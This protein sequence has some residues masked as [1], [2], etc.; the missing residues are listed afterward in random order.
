M[1][2]IKRHEHL[3]VHARGDGRLMSPAYFCLGGERRARPVLGAR[4]PCGAPFH[5][6]RWTVRVHGLLLISAHYPHILT[7]GHAVECAQWHTG[8][9]NVEKIQGAESP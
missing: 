8:K 1:N 9:Q 2:A 6:A 7:V 5:L 3:R 4:F